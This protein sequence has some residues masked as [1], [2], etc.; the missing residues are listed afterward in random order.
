MKQAGQ[1]VFAPKV[2]VHLQFV[3]R[4]V[5]YLEDKVWV[6][7]HDLWTGWWREV[8]H[9]WDNVVCG[10]SKV[11]EVSVVVAFQSKIS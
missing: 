2:S 9:G 5:L 8:E 3:W 4:G 7:G 1:A 10:F 6:G 11:V